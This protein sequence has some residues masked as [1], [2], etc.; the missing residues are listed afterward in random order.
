MYNVLRDARDYKLHAHTIQELHLAEE[1]YADELFIHPPLFVYLSALLHG[2]T[3]VPLP[4]IPILLQVLVMCLLPVI[5]FS[6][7]R[8]VDQ[9]SLMSSSSSNRSSAVAVRAGTCAMV[10]FSCCP[11]IAFCSQKFW[12]DNALMMAV[13]VCVAAHVWLICYDTTTAHSSAAAATYSCIHSLGWHLLSGFVFGSVGLSCKIT[14]LALLPFGVGWILL[15]QY[16]E[17]VHLLTVSTKQ[18]EEHRTRVLGAVC[19][20]VVCVGVYIIGAVLTYAPW[21]YLYW[22][23]NSCATDSLTLLFIYTHTYCVHN[24]LA[25]CCR[26]V[27]NSITQVGIRPTPGPPPPCCSALPS[28]RQR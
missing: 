13:T 10:L 26:R 15:Q 25:H 12:I 5:T 7:L 11:V 16:V 23:S 19:W 2:Y 22:V 1:N 14:A 18:Q 28:C 8:C 9:I 4:V 17:Y 20:A 3:Y 21:A 24:S 6:V 27:C